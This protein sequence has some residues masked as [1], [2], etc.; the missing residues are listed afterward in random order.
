VAGVT[1]TVDQAGEQHRLAKIDVFDATI[2]LQQRIAVA[3]GG[4]PTVLDDD[5][6]GIEYPPIVVDGDH[7][8]ADEHHRI[9]RRS[10][11]TRLTQGAVLVL[12]AIFRRLVLLWAVRVPTDAL[13]G[14]LAGAPIRT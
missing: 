13:R 1:V 12:C 5:R 3:D 2:L 10:P 11:H 14:A 7:R 6:A 4:D 9:R 8:A